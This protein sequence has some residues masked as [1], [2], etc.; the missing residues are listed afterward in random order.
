M[1]T[2]T[3]RQYYSLEGLRFAAVGIGG[4]PMLVFLYDQPM[5][6]QSWQAP[7][8]IAGIFLFFTAIAAG[9]WLKVGRRAPQPPAPPRP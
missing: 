9:A 7:M 4:I 3:E 6:V 1:G 2:L 5:R 8:M